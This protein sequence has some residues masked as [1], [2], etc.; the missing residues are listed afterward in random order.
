MVFYI[1]NRHYGWNANS[2]YLY[3]ADIVSKSFIYAGDSVTQRT[4]FE[5]VIL[6]DNSQVRFIACQG[7]ILKPGFHAK[8]GSSF[9]A[10]IDSD[11]CQYCTSSGYPTTGGYQKFQYNRNIEEKSSDNQVNES[12]TLK[13][14]LYPNPSKGNVHLELLNKNVTSFIYKVYDLR[15]RLIINQR[16]KGNQTMLTLSKGFYLIHIKTQEQWTTRKLIIR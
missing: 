8:S 15:G 1:Q 10:K 4:D 11:L 13:V 6:D 2:N 16:V 14:K 7:I 12:K 9:H 5:P 3:K